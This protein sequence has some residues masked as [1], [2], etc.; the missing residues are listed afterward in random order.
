MKSATVQSFW[1]QY[2]NLNQQIRS[3]AKKAY[4]LW[5]EDP[6]HPSLRFKCINRDENIWSVRITLGYRA[7]GVL[8]EDTVTWFWVGSHDEYER[9]SG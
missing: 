2:R 8:D 5:A 3:R 9:F 6:F 1:E 7:L 4:Q